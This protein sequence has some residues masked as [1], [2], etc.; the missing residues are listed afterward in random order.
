MKKQNLTPH[1]QMQQ[2]A[3]KAE[4]MLKQLANAKR[5]IILCNLVNQSKTVGELCKISNLSQSAVSQHLAKLVEQKLIVGKKT[6][7]EVHY[8]L[9]SMEVQAILST[10]YLIYCKQ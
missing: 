3:K 7:R 8:T 4:A 10:L 9:A 5:L 1:E 2:N 6:G